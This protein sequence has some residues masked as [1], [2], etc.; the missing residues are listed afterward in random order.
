MK[1][2]V[3]TFL[4]TLY[5]K[6]SHHPLFFGQLLLLRFFKDAYRRIGMKIDAGYD[7]FSL[8]VEM[9]EKGACITDV[10]TAFFLRCAME[11]NHETIFEI[12]A[13]DG[14]RIISLKRL[15]PDRQC[16]EIDILNNYMEPFELCGVKFRAFEKESFSTT[17][18]SPL[19]TCNG[20]LSYLN[21]SA[22]RDF[23]KMLKQKGYCLAIVEPTP[24]SSV[25]YDDG[26]LEV[27]KSIPRSGISYYHNYKRI[28]TECGFQLVN[29]VIQGA[30]RSISWT[31]QEVYCRYYFRPAS[32]LIE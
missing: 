17:L 15:L 18:R 29:P 26:R 20:T 5:R 23:L 22:L 27:Q 12:G 21:E 30:L 14:S 25:I 4:I 10:P 3:K 24:L 6:L 8:K 7:Y 1:S 2:F 16:F 9:D 32:P 19:L 31:V 28:F 13:Y 11:Y